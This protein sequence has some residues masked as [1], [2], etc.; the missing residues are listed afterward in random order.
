[1]DILNVSISS[2]LW[3]IPVHANPTN[4]ED[5]MFINAMANDILERNKD[6]IIELT[7]KIINSEIKKHN[8][9]DLRKKT[10]LKNQIIKNIN[11]NII[12]TVLN[13][14]KEIYDSNKPP[15]DDFEDMMK[16]EN[17]I[18]IFDFTV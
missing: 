4:E 17:S 3:T 8:I 15:V 7:V 10:V 12:N 9:V 18:A 6:Y 11:Y 1:M 16:E 14:A 2:E 5:A 13:I